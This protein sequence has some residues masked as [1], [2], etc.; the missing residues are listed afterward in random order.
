MDLQHPVHGATHGVG[1]KVVPGKEE[2]PWPWTSTV[3][4][5]RGMQISIQ[6]GGWG[7]RALHASPSGLSL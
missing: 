7:R 4:E 2:I 5:S 3:S 1:H 6:C